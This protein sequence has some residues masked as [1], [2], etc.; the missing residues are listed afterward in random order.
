MTAPADRLATLRSVA[1]DYARVALENIHREYPNHQALGVSGP[2]QYREPHERHPAFYGSFD[3]H[4]CVEMHWVLVRLL[5][6]VP[7]AVDGERIRAALR[8]HLNSAALYAEMAYARDNPAFERPYG[9]AWLLQLAA[10]LEGWDDPDGRHWATAVAPLAE[11]F[12]A[13]FVRWLPRLP[14]PVRHGVHANTAFALSRSLAF[15]RQRA[16]SDGPAGAL[17]PAL[18][19]A[20]DRFFGADTAYPAAWEPSG[21]DFLSPALVEAELMARRL[22]VDRFVDWLSGFLPALASGQPTAIFTPATVADAT[23]GQGAHLVGLN[24]SRAW[25]WRRLADALPS[26]DPRIPVLTDAAER[27]AATSLGQ[28]VGSHYMVEHWLAA[29]ALLFLTDEDNADHAN[30]NGTHTTASR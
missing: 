7:D 25:C 16:S 11:Q 17:L 6:T 20:A 24:L 18:E 28:V 30:H 10:D 21:G 8:H 27:H 23:D 9:W 29:Y 26:T 1:P 12:A 13:E 22:P 15:A 2:G 3:W 19:A 14:Y 4:S 5:R